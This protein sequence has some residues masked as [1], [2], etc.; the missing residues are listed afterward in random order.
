MNEQ[1]LNNQLEFFNLS[2]CDACDL[3][4][5]RTKQVID[6]K[7]IRTSFDRYGKL[8]KPTSAL[9]RLFFYILEREHG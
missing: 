2:L 7:H 4:Y 8:A 6:P 5:I 3:I 1:E 9:F